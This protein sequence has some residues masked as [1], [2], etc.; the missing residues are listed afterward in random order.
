VKITPYLIGDSTYP[1]LIYL[2]KNWKSHNSNDV[3]KKRYNNNMTFARVIIENV[4]G[5]LKNR[6][7]R[8][9]NFNSSVNRALAIVVACCVLQN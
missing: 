1:L 5:S 4:F 9:K 2:H 3:N 7:W 8:L 6:W